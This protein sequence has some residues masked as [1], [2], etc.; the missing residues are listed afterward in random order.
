M[1]RVKGRPVSAEG[2]LEKEMRVYDYLDRLGLEYER[3]DHEVAMTMEAC[4]KIDL[5]LEATIC[6]NLFLCNRQET[7]FYLLLMPGDKKFK[8]R[9]LSK[10]IG[11]SRLSFAKDEYLLKYLDLTPGSVSVLG[12][13]NDKEKKVR[14][15]IDEDVT[16]GE[17]IG[18]HPCI[19]TSSI[20]L[21]T[22][23]L[24]NVILPDLGYEPVMV[25]LEG[26]GGSVYVA[27]SADVLGETELGKDVSIWYR[28]VVR[29]DLDKIVIG[30]GS[31]I[32]DGCVLHVDAGHPV[33]IGEY[34]TVGHGAILHGCTV[35]DHSL[36]G[37]GAIVLNGAVIGKNCI[38]G[39]GALVTQGT[40]IPDGMMAL[41]SP[42]KIRRPLSEEEIR[43]NEGS[44]LEY[45]ENARRQLT[46]QDHRSRAESS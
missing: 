35:G 19:N 6:K 24:L 11:T 14:L 31:N 1:E 36:I 8:T 34:V 21:K 16:R 10:Q 40:V 33:Q 28:A 43:Q 32:Q 29:A 15:L 45:I 26:D 22:S 44:A 9:E 13:M 12:L 25:H 37:M 5:A 41:G 38:I 20:R 18:C 30:K 46:A 7:D 17:Y 39:A 2:R 3:I 27:P 23:D 42:A 4:A